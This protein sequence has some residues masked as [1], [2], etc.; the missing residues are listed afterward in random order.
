MGYKFTIKVNWT[1]FANQERAFEALVL[2]KSELS[3]KKITS[4]AQFGLP[5]RLW[6]SLLVNTDIVKD[7]TRWADVPHAKLRQLAEQLTAGG[8]QVTGKSTFKD[9][10]VTAG[11]VALDEV[12]FK[13]MESKKFSGLYFAGEVLDIDGITGGFN[14]QA[15]WSTGWLAARAISKMLI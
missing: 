3:A 15:A 7:D 5:S 12:N 9:E 8:Y 11:G 14:F 10:F 1:S 13:T 6:E 4:H 2:L